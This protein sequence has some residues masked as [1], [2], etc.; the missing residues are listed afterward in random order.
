MNSSQKEPQLNRITEL[1]TRL[2]NPPQ[3]GM[4]TMLNEVYQYT[5][6]LLPGI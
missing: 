5:L 1:L 6:N 3:T 4:S 2:E